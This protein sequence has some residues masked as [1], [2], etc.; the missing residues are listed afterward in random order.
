MASSLSQINTRKPVLS[1]GQSSFLPCDSLHM[2]VTSPNGSAHFNN[3]D[4]VQLLPLVV[5]TTT[6]LG[7]ILILI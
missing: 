2:I 3:S 6:T 1:N 7:C 4:Q 5:S